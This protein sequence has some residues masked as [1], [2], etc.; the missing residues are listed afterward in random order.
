MAAAPEQHLNEIVAG[1]ATGMLVTRMADG[2]MHARPLA[3]AADPQRKDGG[4][5]YFATSIK[6]PKVA[7]IEGDPSVLVTFQ[8]K[9]TW[10]V[11]AGA[12]EVVRDRALIERLWSEDWRVFFPGGRDDPDVCILAITPCAGE[13][14]DDRGM[15]AL[16]ASAKG[17]IT[18]A[19]GRRLDTDEAHDHAKVQRGKPRR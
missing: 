16:T 6:S 9:A 12:A 1:F 18:R 4:I 11:I 8:G 5:I 17:A 15:A 14:W 13:Y 3:V 2:G 19:T 10:A 7:E